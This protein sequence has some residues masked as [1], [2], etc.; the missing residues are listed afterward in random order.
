MPRVE[1]RQVDVLHLG[2]QRIP[3]VSGLLTLA[4]DEPSPG[5]FEHCHW[6]L[7]ALAAQFSD[8]RLAEVE[9]RAELE[10]G[11]VLEGPAVVVS[12]NGRLISLQS[13]GD[14]KGIEGW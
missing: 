10:D 14:W 7:D 2:A 5:V 9:V 11:D 4:R 13:N 3:L 12:S 1:R 8:V 6:R